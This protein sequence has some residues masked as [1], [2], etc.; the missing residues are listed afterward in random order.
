MARPRLAYVVLAAGASRRFGG[1]KQLATVDFSQTML[2]RCLDT[3][4]NLA[5]GELFLVLGAEHQRIA[6]TLAL[7]QRFPRVRV[8]INDMWQE[9]VASSIRRTLLE[10]AGQSYH[11]L[12]ILLGDQIAIT[13][14]PLKRMR[15]LWFDNRDTIIAS[16]YA[17]TLGVPAIFP[18]C[19][20]SDLLKLRGDQGAKWLIHQ[21]AHNTVPFVLPEAQWDID[22]ER[23]L[24]DWQFDA[25]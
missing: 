20:F 8:L 19:Y 4:L 25:I 11:G 6:E 18:A 23:Q 14:E 24:N 10:M 21:E 5:P 3:A 13:P 15:D 1:C 17:Q 16:A 2:E 7:A 9:G 12:F 22:T